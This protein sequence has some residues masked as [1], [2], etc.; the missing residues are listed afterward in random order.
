MKKRKRYVDEVGHL[1][2]LETYGVECPN[3]SY[4]NIVEWESFMKKNPIEKF[5]DCYVGGLIADTL[6]QLKGKNLANL[7]TNIKNLKIKFN[8]GGKGSLDYT[9]KKRSFLENC[10]LYVQ[11]VILSALKQNALII[12]GMVVPMGEILTTIVL[13]AI[14]GVGLGAAVANIPKAMLKIMPKMLK[15][16]SAFFKM[17]F[18]SDNPIRGVPINFFSAP[19]FLL[20]L[21]PV[22]FWKFVLT[23]VKRRIISKIP[24]INGPISTV[25]EFIN[26]VSGTQP[27]IE[28][29]NA[30]GG[31][32]KESDKIVGKLTFAS[33]KNIGLDENVNVG[34]TLFLGKNMY[35][36]KDI[37][38]YFHVFKY[39]HV[40]PDKSVEITSQPQKLRYSHYISDPKCPDGIDF[41]T[42]SKNKKMNRCS[43]MTM[44]KKCAK[45]FK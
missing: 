9:S 13:P 18:S 26:M 19:I 16:I 28:S 33:R 15:S 21:L 4:E 20:P 14:T 11:I 32:V 37:G 36:Y 35:C 8:G 43:G 34:K 24:V 44:L 31:P 27:T 39:T 41:Y 45:E 7:L 5:D 17:V 1:F 40:N 29:L 38:P 42:M 2:K 6:S 30:I 10:T 12:E 25:M 23:Y 3:V 22:I